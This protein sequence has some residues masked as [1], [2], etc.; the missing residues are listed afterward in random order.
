MAQSCIPG[1]R[2]GALAWWRPLD[3]RVVRTGLLSEAT[4]HP[5]KET[6]HS[7]AASMNLN[8]AKKTSSLTDMFFKWKHLPG[9]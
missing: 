2:A 5:V 4:E 8:S 6:P 7:R 3:E 9:S 1:G